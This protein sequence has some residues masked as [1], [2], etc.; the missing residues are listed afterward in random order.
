MD[1]AEMARLVVAEAQHAQEQ[2]DE[3]MLEMFVEVIRRNRPEAVPDDFGSE[4]QAATP[5]TDATTDMPPD[6]TDLR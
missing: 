2:N 4:P 3:D 6:A 5:G 1:N